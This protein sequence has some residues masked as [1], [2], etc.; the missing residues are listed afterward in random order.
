MCQGEEGILQTPVA[1][2]SSAMLTIRQQYMSKTNGLWGFIFSSVIFYDYCFI[3]F[4]ST[5]PF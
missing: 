3:V 1:E 5:V 4:I 2:K